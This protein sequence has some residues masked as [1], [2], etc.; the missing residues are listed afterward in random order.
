MPIRLTNGFCDDRED[1]LKSSGMMRIE[2]KLPV[3]SIAAG[4][5]LLCPLVAE[6]TATAKA[7]KRRKEKSEVGQREHKAGAD[8]TIPL[9]AQLHHR[10]KTVKVKKRETVVDPGQGTK[11]ERVSGKT[12]NEA[13]QRAPGRATRPSTCLRFL[14]DFYGKGVCDR[15]KDCRFSHDF[16]KGNPAAPAQENNDKHKKRA[17][18]RG[19]SKDKKGAANGRT[20][21]T[22]APPRIS[23]S[24]N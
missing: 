7:R 16:P 12:G 13:S 6:R 5:I 8:L 19:K 15:G 18:S 20:A 2:A 22:P 9:K 3:P 1:S 4:E 23:L 14:A 21:A 10:F 11:E 17:K 24:G